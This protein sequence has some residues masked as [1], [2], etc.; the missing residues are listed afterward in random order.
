MDDEFVCL[1]C[2][3][4]RPMKFL[5]E[6]IAEEDCVMVCEGQCEYEFLDH[7]MANQQIQRAERF[8]V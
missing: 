8:Y 6:E 5:C 2:A 1:M 4:E 7:A 3:Q